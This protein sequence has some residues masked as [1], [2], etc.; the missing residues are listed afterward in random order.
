LAKQSSNKSI[1][2]Q[3]LAEKIGTSSSTVSRALN[4][5]P[6]ISLAMKQKV[7]DM[8]IQMGYKP[9][10]PSLMSENETKTI[11]L[12]LPNIT[13]SYYREIIKSVRQIVEQDGFALFICEAGYQAEKERFFFEQIE[14][15]KMQGLI[16]LAHR[17]SDEQ[18]ILEIFA[19]KRF[20]MVFIHENK[21]KEKV[22]TVILDVYQSLSEA[23]DHLKSNEAKNIS[24]LIDDEQNP[25]NSQIEELFLQLVKSDDESDHAQVYHINS[26]D[27]FMHKQLD[28]VLKSAHVPDALIISSMQMAYAVQQLVSK[29]S[30][31]TEKLLLI[32]LTKDSFNTFARPKISY[33]KLQGEQIGGAAA[34]L[35]FKQIK[36]GMKAESKA[37]FS[38]LIIKSSSMRM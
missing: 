13:N 38:R 14:L 8:A 9:S 34:K 22:P 20:P 31:D 36:N 25:I 26:D 33:F 28:A 27:D 23:V 15:M 11:A 17:D 35:L 16:Y 2:I 21:L 29:G 32:S 4:D 24:L 7:L 6:K 12:I 5:H 30:I 10:I 1:R 3:D 18:E 37:F 19:K